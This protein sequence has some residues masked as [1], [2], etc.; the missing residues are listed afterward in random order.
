MNYLR[1]HITITMQPAALKAFGRY[2]R[3]WLKGHQPRAPDNKKI[4]LKFIGGYSKNKKCHKVNRSLR[5]T[6]YYIYTLCETLSFSVFVA[7]EV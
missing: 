6:K 5:Y 3:G 7:T 1:Y 2:G 4:S